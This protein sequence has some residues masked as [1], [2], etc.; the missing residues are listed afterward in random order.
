MEP[1]KVPEVLKSKINF[2]V[3]AL[4]IGAS[5]A[6]QTFVYFAAE[7]PDLNME[8]DLAFVSM[9]LPLIVSVVSFFIAFKYGLSQVF[10]KSYLFLALAFFSYFLAEVTYYA[11]DEIFGIEPYPSIADVFFF[12]LYAFAIVHILINFRFFKTKTHISH[13]LLFIAIPIVIFSVYFYI[14]LEEIGEAD[15]DFFY[16]II[17]VGGAAVTL[18]LAALGA[19]V[20]RGGLLGIVWSILLIGLLGFAIGDVWYY[21]LELFGEYDLYH[22]VNLF[23]YAGNW[24]IIYSLYKHSKAI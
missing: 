18:S 6:F 8:E 20:F 11:Y 12:G 14:S 5:I 16:G 3:F 10:G 9:S 21:Y 17:F 22:P 2:R 15:F 19:L 23:W 4:I 1:S 7:S 24:V 13:K